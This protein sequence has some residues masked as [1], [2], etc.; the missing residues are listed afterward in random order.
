VVDDPGLGEELLV[1]DGT[2][3]GTS[4]LDLRP[5]PGS[6]RPTL[7]GAFEDALLFGCD[8]GLH[9]PEIWATSGT[10]ASTV[11]LTDLPG[12]DPVRALWRVG[13]DAFVFAH[14]D[15]VHGVELW[16]LD[17]AGARLVA[18]LVPGASGAVDAFLGVAGSEAYFV[19]FDGT[20]WRTDGTAPGTSAVFQGLR[21][22]QEFL[23]AGGDIYIDHDDGV[24][25]DE[26]H[27]LVAGATAER[28]G[29][30]CGVG[31][32]APWIESD[33]PL[34]AAAFHVRCGGGAPGSTGLLA[35]GPRAAL[36]GWLPG[37]CTVFVELGASR[38]LALMPDGAMA[39]D[40]WIM[41][42]NL[43]SLIGV[44]VLLQAFFGPTSNPAGL[45]TSAGIALRLGTW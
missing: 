23:V 8:D 45:E 9:G 29:E 26:P 43:P 44:E 12:T 28:V 33:D 41:V 15:G 38:V 27:V 34:L 2:S 7:L 30:P 14:D 19:G 4:V 39:H 10:L 18:D 36:P 31:S 40:S 24:H 6:S 35:L 13:L 37:G 5:G 21:S 16:R 22:Q 11:R 42:P 3:T 17:A 32:R 1:T 25:G 20:L